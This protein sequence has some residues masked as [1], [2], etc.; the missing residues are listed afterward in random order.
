M[1]FDAEGLHRKT[2]HEMWM[3]TGCRPIHLNLHLHELKSLTNNYRITW[4]RCS[5]SEK[6]S[7]LIFPG[8]VVENRKTNP[9]TTMSEDDTYDDSKYGA[10][11][12]MFDKYHRKDKIQVRITENIT[13]D[14]W[15][16]ESDPGHIQSGLYLWPAATYAARY[17]SQIWSSLPATNYVIELGA[18]CGLAGCL[19]DSSVGLSD[20]VLQESRLQNW[21]V[22]E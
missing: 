18:G 19:T 8:F 10:I 1:V 14:L 11:G 9:G 7:L 17:L 22:S 13:V 12:F 6:N 21:R 3:D 15:A 2:R 4:Y 5:S 20:P 16:I